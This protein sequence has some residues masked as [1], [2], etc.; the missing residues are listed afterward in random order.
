MQEKSQ[1]GSFS[2]ALRLCLSFGRVSS[3]SLGTGTRKTFN[4]CHGSDARKLSTWQF[5]SGS[6]SVSDSDPEEQSA[7]NVVDFEATKEPS[8]WK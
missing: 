3:S 6:A 2:L 4:G 8:S 1:L 7:I 5:H